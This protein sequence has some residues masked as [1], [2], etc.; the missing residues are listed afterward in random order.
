MVAKS[1]TASAQ[2]VNFDR[3]A[4]FYD[5]TRGFPIGVE[6]QVAQLITK[7]AGLT[8]ESRVLEIGIGTG[9]IARP[10]AQYVRGIVGV[11]LSR[12]MLQR[13]LAQSQATARS[14][15]G[16]GTDRSA[17]SNDLDSIGESD[18]SNAT[19]RFG[20]SSKAGESSE[21]GGP[22]AGWIELSLADATRLPF[23]D[24]CFD[25]AIGVHVLHLIPGWREVLSEIA[26]VL[27]P[28][29]PLVN[30]ADTRRMRAVWDLWSK[31]TGRERIVPDVGASPAELD[32]FLEDSGWR[33]TGPKQ[34]FTFSAPVDL[35]QF[36]TGFAERSW[37]ST[38]RL[39]D[40]ELD[41]FVAQMRAAVIEL[42]G[43]V[44]QT[45]ES[46]A[47]FW[48]RAYTPPGLESRPD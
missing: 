21:T 46:Q 25:A 9:R 48:A 34:A 16:E 44:N 20:E 5:E 24:D 15:S 35:R 37:S 30:A 6:R 40:A 32:A 45:V 1:S 2:A 33:P 13:L 4:A 17:S 22:E 3:A 11:D 47:G 43:D 39:Q 14:G 12:A 8:P 28:G 23:P 26:R 10:L 42:Y 7:T 31:S 41:E 19:D 18:R 36:L 29:A 38:W 27:R